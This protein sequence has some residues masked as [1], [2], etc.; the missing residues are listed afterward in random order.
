LHLVLYHRHL[1]ITRIG[2]EISKDA[3]DFVVFS[4]IMGHDPKKNAREVFS[5][6]L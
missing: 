4:K 3:L 5:V 6:T 2:Y 1:Q